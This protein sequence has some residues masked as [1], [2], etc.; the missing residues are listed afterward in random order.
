MSYSGFGQADMTFVEVALPAGRVQNE[1]YTRGADIAIDNVFGPQSVAALNAMLARAGVA[2]PSGAYT[3]SADRRTVYFTPRDPWDR[4]LASVRVVRQPPPPRTG[5]MTTATAATTAAIPTA[6]PGLPPL[7][8][9]EPLTI[10]PASWTP[11]LIAGGV[12][13]AGVGVFIMM[14]PRGRA[15]GERH[16][17]VPPAPAVPVRRRKAGRRRLAMAAN[18]RR[19]RRRA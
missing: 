13:L 11:W 16:A 10:G 9:E 17:I 15:P 8:A 7:P 1:L 2:S 19:R 18:R 12:V 3:V 5:T 14:A 4:L 6:V